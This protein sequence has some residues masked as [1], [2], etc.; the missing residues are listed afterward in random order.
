MIRRPPR[1]TRTDT[2]FPYTTLFRSRLLIGGLLYGNPGRM[3][4][5]A[6]YGDALALKRARAFEAAARAGITYSFDSPVEVPTTIAWGTKDRLLPYAQ[7]SIARLRL[8][9]AHHVPLVGAGHVPM[10]D[11]P[12]RIIALIAETV[13]EAR[14]AASHVACGARPASCPAPCP[15][16]V[17][18]AQWEERRVGKAGDVMGS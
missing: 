13:A 15:A 2:L 5:G 8:P 3:T 16:A 11:A 17:G 14:S 1:S 18:P 4:A 6:T 12:E 10:I 9:N 7:A